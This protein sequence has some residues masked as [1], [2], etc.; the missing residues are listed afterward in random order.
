MET[1]VAFAARTTVI[2]HLDVTLARPA[3]LSVSAA[4]CSTRTGACAGR[5]ARTTALPTP[6][7]K[8]RRNA[9]FLLPKG[10][11]AIITVSGPSGR[12]L[13]R[14]VHRAAPG[15]GSGALECTPVANLNGQD[16]QVDMSC[17]GGK[18]DAYQVFT[19][20]TVIQAQSA[21]AAVSCLPSVVTGAAGTLSGPAAHCSAQQGS[22]AS[23]RV[24][25]RLEGLNPVCGDLKALRT[26]VIVLGSPDIPS[27]P[28]ATPTC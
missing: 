5:V 15:S 10:P 21:T 9:R 23:G 7:G 27:F 6:A 3:R 12:E 2:V 18:F 24:L 19:P 1:A 13:A 17:T 20:R 25:I 4:I 22:I 28:V 14:A 16:I 11:R 8:R 26:Q